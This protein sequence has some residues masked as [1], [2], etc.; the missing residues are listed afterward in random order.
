MQGS[1][2][3]P[4]VHLLNSKEKQVNILD[5]KIGEFAYQIISNQYERIIKHEV[6]V[7]EDKDPE[8][9]HQM[10]VAFRHLRTAIELFDGVVIVPKAASV[11]KIR[12]LLKSLGSLRD[13]DVQL[14]AVQKD[15][16]KQGSKD[17]KRLIHRVYKKLH[18]QRCQA[19]KAVKQILKSKQ[20]QQFRHACAEWLDQPIYQPLAQVSMPMI[21]PE[22]LLPL[23]AQLFA[24][25]AWL[26]S[27]KDINTETSR[28]MH[29]L[30]KYCKHVRYQ[31]EFFSDFYGNC[32]RDWIKNLKD[33]QDRLGMLQD[34]YVFLDMVHSLGAQQCELHQLE[35]L[36]DCKRLDALSLWEDY[37]HQYL[38]LSFR[39]SIYS[40]IIGLNRNNHET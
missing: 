20:Y 21:L 10:R 12:S 1:L 25:P 3:L 18:K 31:S 2:I 38:S 13:L 24:H 8:H 5:L 35:S 27:I 6:G 32:F 33:L 22:L 17:E 23:V 26:L 11:P 36:T 4:D 29:D 34:S 40:I 28:L 39:H 15:Y 37:R 30:R 7:L 9:L 16:A 19:L 14:E